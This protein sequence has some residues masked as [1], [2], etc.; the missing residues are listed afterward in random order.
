MYQTVKPY[1]FNDGGYKINNGGYY[2]F[3]N[4]YIS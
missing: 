2:D 4:A 1:M 3:N